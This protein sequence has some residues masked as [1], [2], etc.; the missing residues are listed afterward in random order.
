MRLHTP[1]PIIGRE[2]KTELTLEGIKIPRGTNV[3]VNI[4]ALHH[5]EAVWGEDYNVSDP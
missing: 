1:V 5:N 4:F 3:E 2:V